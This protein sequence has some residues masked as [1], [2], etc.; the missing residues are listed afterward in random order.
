MQLDIVGIAEAERSDELGG[1]GDEM[2]DP[3]LEYGYPGKN[4]MTF[5]R[6]SHG[7]GFVK[8]KEV[9]GNRGAL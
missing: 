7:S 8:V 3:T 1:P 5:V 2:V 4:E 6:V 9:H